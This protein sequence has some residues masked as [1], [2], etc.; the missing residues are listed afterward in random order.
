[1]KKLFEEDDNEYSGVDRAKILVTVLPFI[2]IIIIL[3]ITLIVN[4]IKKKGDDLDDLQKNIMEYTDENQEA[5]TEESSQQTSSSSVVNQKDD[6]D[7]DRSGENMPAG[8]TQQD[9]D[10]NGENHGNDA[11]EEDISAG[12]S[13]TPYQ[14]AMKAQKDYSKVSFHT[15]EQ[16]KDMMAYWSD[17]NQK[18]INDLVY[19]D[20]YLAM[21]WSLKGTK[22]FYYYGDTNGNGQPNGKGVAVYADNQYYY[23]DWANGMRSGKGTW[24]HFHIHQTT[25]SN[26]L[27]TYHHYTGEWVNDLPQGEG[28]EHYDYDMNLITGND[29]YVTNRIGSYDAGLVNGEFYIITIYEDNSIKEWNAEADHGTWVY[30]N[31]NKDKKGNRTV[32]VEI[33]DPNNYVWLH[34]KKNVGIGVPCLIVPESKTP[35]A[36]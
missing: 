36:S 23:G 2:L 18:A 4:S 29:G 22:N 3:A 31:E 14:E 25:N 15:P 6:S 33:Q 30:Q 16:L 27:Y 35:T 24:M 32:Y 28:S 10:D 13:P 12:A 20:H 8:Q 21:S 34:P 11:G 9:G 1:M 5:R 19:L 26:D 7:Q 17:N